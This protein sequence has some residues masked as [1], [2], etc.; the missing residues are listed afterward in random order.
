MM[1]NQEAEMLLAVTS[2]VLI[3]QQLCGVVSGRTLDGIKSKRRTNAYRDSVQ[4]LLAE[5]R[6]AVIHGPV[7]TP[8]T[9]AGR[10]R[11]GDP[12]SPPVP[13]DGELAVNQNWMALVL[14]YLVSLEIRT[15][16]SNQWGK[17]ILDECI[18]SLANGSRSVARDLSWLT[19]RLDQHVDALYAHA[20]VVSEGQ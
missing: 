14:E 1:A 7:L 9:Q 16:P 3:N 10:A 2:P 15:D 8:P 19:E 18:D 5:M 20:R 4:S 17:A 6:V 11:R 13:D 12:N